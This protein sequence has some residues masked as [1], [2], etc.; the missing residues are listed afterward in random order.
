[1]IQNDWRVTLLTYLY[2]DEDRRIGKLVESNGLTT[3]TQYLINHE[4][5][6]SEIML[7]RTQVNQ[8]AWSE[9]IYLHTPDGIGEF[10]MRQVSYLYQ[11]GQGSTQLVTDNQVLHI[12]ST[13]MGD[14]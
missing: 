8:G 13:T 12:L 6:Y 9:T 4:G 11:D 1:M 14:L 3:E 7:E 2:D 10:E 5:F